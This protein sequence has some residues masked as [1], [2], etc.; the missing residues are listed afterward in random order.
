MSFIRVKEVAW[1]RVINI[2]R[3]L[4]AAFNKQTPKKEVDFLKKN[5]SM[6]QAFYSL[7]RMIDAI[8]CMLESSTVFILSSS[9]KGYKI[10]TSAFLDKTCSKTEH[11]HFISSKNRESLFQLVE[12]MNYSRLLWA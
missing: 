6:Y 7:F 12:L 2:H 8:C 1:L 11:F 5:F 4:Q 10:R 3:C 9:F